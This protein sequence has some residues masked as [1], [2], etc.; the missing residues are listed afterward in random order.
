MRAREAIALLIG[1]HRD[2][3]RRNGRTAY[4][5][6]TEDALNALLGLYREAVRLYRENGE[7]ARC[8]GLLPRWLR[9]MPRVYWPVLGRAAEEGFDA[10]GAA[11]HMRRAEETM[12]RKVEGEFSLLREMRGMDAA[13][14][15]LGADVAREWG[16]L[17]RTEEESSRAMRLLLESEDGFKSWMGVRVDITGKVREIIINC[18][19]LWMR[20]Y[21]N[22][23]PS[24]RETLM[25][26]GLYPPRV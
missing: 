16:R 7:W 25:G 12:R 11:L 2:L 18:T 26:R 8:A 19:E 23:Y 22:E 9:G 24:A 21:P 13:I 1:R 5:R 4:N 14:R 6:E 3:V 10:M 17:M 15:S 20:D